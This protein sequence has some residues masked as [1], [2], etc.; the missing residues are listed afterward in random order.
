[1]LEAAWLPS[2]SGLSSFSDLLYCPVCYFGEIPLFFQGSPFCCPLLPPPADALGSAPHPCAEY[3]G[4]STTFLIP[5]FMG[6]EKGCSPRQRKVGTRDGETRE[7][8]IPRT[9]GAGKTKWVGAGCSRQRCDRKD[10]WAGQSKEK[11]EFR[12]ASSSSA[13]NI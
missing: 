5:F 7:L 4:L 13:N 9:G 11:V 2:A 3:A 6:W 12:G 1:M 8:P 10:P